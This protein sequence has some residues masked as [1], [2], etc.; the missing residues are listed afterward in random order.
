[1][2]RQPGLGRTCDELAHGILR[3]P[4]GN[5][6]I[7]YRLASQRIEIIRILHSARDIEAAFRDKED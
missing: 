1:M 4:M 6:V 3:F 2:A 5:Y 7:F